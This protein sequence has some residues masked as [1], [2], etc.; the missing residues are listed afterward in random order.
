MENLSWRLWYR[1]TLVEKESKQ[2]HDVRT[3]IPIQQSSQQQDNDYFSYA[4]STS[5]APLQTPPSFKHVSPSSFKRILTSLGSTDNKTP[6]HHTLPSPQQ[7]KEQ[8]SIDPPLP[9][10]VHTPTP[11]ILPTNTATPVPFP[12]ITTTTTT[13]TATTA[14]TITATIKTTTATSKFFVSDDEDDDDDEDEQQA[15]TID[16][17]GQWSTVEDNK[18]SYYPI[19]F[20]KNTRPKLTSTA[21][22][23]TSLLSRMLQQQ[24]VSTKVK[25]VPIINAPSKQRRRSRKDQAE[26][27]RSLEACVEWEYRQN[28]PPFHALQTGSRVEQMDCWESFQGW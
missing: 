17:D 6:L 22:K 5:S 20:R 23:R 2:Q 27:T 16:E 14:T 24:Q 10:P 1:E 26:L 11:V 25:P 15:D 28:A 18:G 19:E 7:E 8:K 21:D 3:P 13:T 12:T 4:S 9:T